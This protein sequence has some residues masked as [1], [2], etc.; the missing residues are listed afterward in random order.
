M[1]CANNID[2]EIFLSSVT[3]LLRAFLTHKLHRNLRA[4]TEPRDNSLTRKQPRD[5]TASYRFTFDNITQ[6]GI[7]QVQ[8]LADISRWRYV[9]IATKPVHQ[10]QIRPT[11]GHTQ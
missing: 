5:L 6:P 7:E 1:S 9:V 4:Q 2:S 8:A 10:W 3:S 11:R